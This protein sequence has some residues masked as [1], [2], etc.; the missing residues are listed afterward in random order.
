MIYITSKRRKMLL[1]SIA[2]LGFI[3]SIVSSG[4]AEPTKEKVFCHYNMG[5]WYGYT[6]YDSKADVIHIQRCTW[7]KGYSCS[8]Y[9]IKKLMEQDGIK[10]FYNTNDEFFINDSNHTEFQD[11]WHW[12]SDCESGGYDHYG[13]TEYAFTYTCPYTPPEKPKQ[14]LIIDKKDKIYAIDVLEK[15]VKIFSSTDKPIFYQDYKALSVNKA[16][17]E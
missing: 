4:Y 14:L 16:L 5:D 15:N 8:E 6:E 3:L 13:L 11:G 10:V 1:K 9:D 2:L 12:K 7:G 17:C